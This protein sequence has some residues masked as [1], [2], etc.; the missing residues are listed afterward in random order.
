M[1][2]A[3]S[4]GAIYN[5]RLMEQHTLKIVN[6]CTNTNIYSYLETS[7]GQSFNL[8]LKV[9]NFFQHQWPV[10]FNFLR[11]KFM[12]FRNK[13]KCLSLASFSSLY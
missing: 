10:L 13:L 8:Y 1:V 6:N 11:S 5:V 7:G 3:Y 4:G 2:V 12:D 9:V